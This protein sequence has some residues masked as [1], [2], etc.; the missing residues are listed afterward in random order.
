MSERYSDKDMFNTYYFLAKS[1]DALN[2]AENAQKC[3]ELAMHMNLTK[4]EKDMLEDRID[5]LEDI[6]RS[7]SR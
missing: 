1:Y 3:L 2:D 6:E 5:D 4:K 7:K